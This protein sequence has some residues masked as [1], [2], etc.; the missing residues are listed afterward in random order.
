MDD[1][2]TAIVERRTALQSEI[3]ALLATPTIEKRDL[4]ATEAQRFTELRDQA[5]AIDERIAELRAEYEAREVANA[6]RAKVAPPVQVGSEPRTYSPHGPNSY[7]RDLAFAALGHDEARQRLIRHAKEVAVEASRNPNGP[8]A[9]A[10]AAATRGEQRALSTVDGSGGTFV[11]PAYLVDEWVQ[12]ARA[13]RVVANQVRRMDLPKGTDSI[14]MPKVTSGTA[15]ALQGTQNTAVTETDLTDT[16]VS[17]SVVTVA[18]QQTVSL[19]LIE[20]SPV[21]FDRVVFADLQAAL[22]QQVDQ[23]VIAGSGSSGQPTGLLNLSGINTVS[24][25]STSPTPTNLWPLLIQ[26]LAEVNNTRFMP[27]Q[28]I[29]MT[30]LR[31]GWLV[32]GQDTTGRPLVVPEAN[33]PW[34]AVGVGSPDIPAGRVGTIAGVPVYVDANIP[35]TLANGGTSTDAA[36]ADQDAII[37]A[38]TD[39]L[40]LYES[41]VTARALP[42]T[43]G[44]QM[45]VLL[46]TYEYLAWLPGRYPQSIAV[47]T[48]EGLS[49]PTF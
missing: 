49:T 42:Q 9:R 31:W 38:R 12:F 33:G 40:Y 2:L 11:P 8:E 16:Y 19:Q 32:A 3:D 34:N 15:V 26:A 17:A 22:A 21:D 24:Y 7:F 29:F 47:I 23:L 44:S 36:T 13:A 10:L 1:L 18:G 45:S 4:N 41:A 43:L 28:A 14:N 37:V 35:Q 46:Q 30:P 6:A 48:G 25:S 5:K 20:Q 27:A 39:D